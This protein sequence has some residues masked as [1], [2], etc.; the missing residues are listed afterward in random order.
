MAKQLSVEDIKLSTGVSDAQLDK[1][2]E[3]DKLWE[4]AQLFGN[5]EEYVETPGFGLSINDIAD[6]NV[7][8]R[9]KSYQQAMVEAFKKWLNMPR[10]DVVT[11]RSLLEML[12]KLDKVLLA[13]LVCRTGEFLTKVRSVS[14]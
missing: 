13:E 3:E 2:L 11:Y 12:I 4:L 10:A 7:I 1:R 14:V 9:N 8:A 6:L 5:H